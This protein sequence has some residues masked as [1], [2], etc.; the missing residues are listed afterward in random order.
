MVDAA[1]PLPEIP[2]PNREALR[3]LVAE[4]R[5]VVIRGLVADWPLVR[6]AGDPRALSRR[7]LAMDRGARVAAL[8]GPPGARGRLFYDAD[9]AGF[10][11]RRL[12]LPLATALDML[13]EGLDDPRPGALA[14]QSLPVRGALAGFEAENPMPLLDDAVE[15]RVWIGNAVTVAAHH[16][17]SENIACVVAGRRTFTLFPPDQVSNLSIGP[18][19]QTPAGTPIS[20]VD[21]DAP[22]LVA[23]PRFAEAMRHA[24]QAT[25]GPGDAIFIPYLWWH[26]VRSTS[27]FNMLVNYWWSAMEP[28][29]GQ[30]LD[31]MLATMAAIRGLPEPKR[32]AWRALFDHYVFGDEA[33]ARAGIPATRQGLLGD[34]PPDRRR[35]LRRQ[36]AAVL[37][38]I[39]T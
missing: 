33:I 19:E 21:F 36:M 38:R 24:R 22:D 37:G 29:R 3:D 13:I 28:A 4:A 5:P 16:D 15:P 14:V 34:L 12:D 7:L 2:P 8:S 31:V 25:L 32:A 35:A 10:N 20:L 9:M 18:F 1:A 26:H 27:P 6:L 23:H 39:D 30:P 17:M 11:F